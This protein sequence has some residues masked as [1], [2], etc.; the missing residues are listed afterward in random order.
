V[1]QD[2]KNVAGKEGTFSPR[3]AWLSQSLSAVSA[4]GL[5]RC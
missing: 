5:Q 2:T 1:W 4:N 3:L